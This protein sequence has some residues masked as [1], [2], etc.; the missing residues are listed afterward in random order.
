M[1]NR[2]FP[3]EIHNISLADGMDIAYVDEGKGSCTLLF[4]HGLGSNLKAWQKNIATLRKDYR[5]IALDLPG[6]GQSVGSE[7]FAYNMS[8][9]A[10]VVRE[11]ID[12]LGLKKV[13]LVGHSMGG[14]I[15][16]HTALKDT[17]KLEKLVLVAPAGFETFT[18]KER[19]WFQTIFTP[20]MLQAT[21]EEQLVKNFHLN[22][23]RFPEDAQFM[24][25]D[26]LQLRQTPA[27]AAYCAMISKCVQG[28]LNEPVFDQ[29]PNVKLSTLIFFG[30][31]DQLIPNGFL[32]ASLTTSEVARS[33]QE[34]LPRGQLKMLPEAGHFVQWEQAEQL[35]K[36]LKEFLK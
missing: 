36:A 2:S 9:F 32:H 28:M 31:N 24:I 20:A 23:H 18:E 29:L 4:I 6:Y 33:G 12:K 5:C 34:A 17:R 7:T 14:Q 26:R 13:V 8:F 1:S 22:F 11:L 25:D 10:A 3:F 21:P 27:Y 19:A 16:L 15:A 30:D 35:N